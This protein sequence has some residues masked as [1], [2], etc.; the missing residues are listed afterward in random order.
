M[1]EPSQRPSRGIAWRSLA[2]SAAA[3]A[4]A[5]GAERAAAQPA[6]STWNPITGVPKGTLERSQVET[7]RVNGRLYEVRIASTA[8]AGEYWLLVVRGTMVIDPDPELESQHNWNIVQPF[9]QRSCKG[10]FAV[11]EDHLVE[12]VNLYIRFRCGG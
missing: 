9:M 4:L 2:V 5:T 1:S 12:R 8:A 3:I 10:P 11:L 7:V 6:D